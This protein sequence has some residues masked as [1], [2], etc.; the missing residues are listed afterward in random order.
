MAGLEPAR[1]KASHFECDVSAIPPHGLTFKNKKME[2]AT[3]IEP[4]VR[5]LQTRALPLGYAAY[6][7][8]NMERKTGFEPATPTLARLY[9]T[10]ELLPQNN[11]GSWI[12]TNEMTESKSVA[13]PLGYTP[14]KGRLKG[15]EPS[16][17]G[18][19]IRCVNHF[20]TTAIICMFMK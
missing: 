11:W 13:L 9:S 17:V 20:A 14:I 7:S 12:R 3:G 2:A 10:T 15:I 4:V 6:M 19:T 8:I 18:T 5:V 1:P 16:S